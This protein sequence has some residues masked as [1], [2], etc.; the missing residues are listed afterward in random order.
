MA[1]RQIGLVF[2]L[3]L[4]WVPGAMAQTTDLPDLST[5]EVPSNMDEVRLVEDL[6]DVPPNHWAYQAV[7]SLMERYGI[8]SGYGD[9]TFRGN[10]SLSRYEFASALSELLAQFESYNKIQQEDLVT[11]RRLQT[12]FQVSL[13]EV[14]KRLDS[15]AGKIALLE[16]QNFSPTTK[17]H[18]QIVQ[19]LTNGTAAPTTTF[20]RVRLDLN[21]SFTGVDALVTQL[22]W[23]NGGGDAVSAAQVL[24]GNRLGTVGSL[25]DGGGLG[26]VGVDNQL[27]LRKLYYRFNP[28]EN[29]MVAVGTALPPSDFVD[30]NTFANNSGDNFASSFFGNNPLI[31]QNAV[32]R[33]GG[34]GVAA[35]WQMQANLAVRGLYASADGNTRLGGDRNQ[36]TLEVEYKFR[37][38]ITGRLQYTHGNVD[39]SRINALGLNGEW[40]LTR[41]F[42]VFGRLGLG[43]Y[44]GFNTN[45]GSNVDLNPRS[46]MLGGTVRNFLITGSTAGAAIGQPFATS[47]LGNATQTNFEAYFGFLLN[48]H[49]NISPSLLVVSNPDNRRGR[50]IWEWAL[51]MV[52][53][54]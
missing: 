13:D 20:S 39:G 27:R 26:T 15:A 42:G 18:T 51:R 48:D 7:K 10:K 33:N 6:S 30:R 4:L 34:A 43:R 12:A 53:E 37:P 36:T 52:F 11:L 54:F 14:R 1:A 8:M 49:I 44:R 9:K 47:K 35:S 17:L 29:V 2:G 3:A 31:V 38:D 25:V 24:R 23:G 21:T 5:P 19:A 22:E 46:W 32:D 50:T 45:L 28:A 16:R 40:A 41:Q